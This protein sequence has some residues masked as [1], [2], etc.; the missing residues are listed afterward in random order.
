M[1]QINHLVKSI[2]VVI[3][4][5]GRPV[6][7]Q[8]NAQLSRQAKMIDITNKINGEWSENLAG[9]KSWSVICQGLYLIDDEAMNALED[10]FMKNHTVEVSFT[11]GNCYYRGDA[12]IIDFPVSSVFNKEFKYTLQLLGTGPLN[13]EEL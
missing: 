3:A 9:T 2:D 1:K 4:V 5:G 13:K 6:G 11:L 12:F 10:A 8:Q 7:G